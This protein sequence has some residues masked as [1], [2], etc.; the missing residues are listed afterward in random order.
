MLPQQAQSGALTLL[1]DEWM[2]RVEERVKLTA[3][4][5][6]L[7]VGVLGAEAVEVGGRLF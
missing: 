2:R 1:G 6:P 4:Q 3:G 7:A 5:P